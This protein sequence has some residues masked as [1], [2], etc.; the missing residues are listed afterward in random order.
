MV[1]RGGW[2]QKNCVWLLKAV[3]SWIGDSLTI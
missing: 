2:G 1:A 3:G